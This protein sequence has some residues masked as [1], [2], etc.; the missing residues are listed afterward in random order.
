MVPATGFDEVDGVPWG[1]V[2]K[3]KNHKRKAIRYSSKPLIWFGANVM[4]TLQLSM[5]RDARKSKLCWLEIYCLLGFQSSAEYKL[6][7]I[8]RV[9]S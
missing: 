4:S 5:G 7:G 6:A 9:T 8:E 2:W 3:M 1:F